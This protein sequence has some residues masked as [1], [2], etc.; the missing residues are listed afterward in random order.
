MW[1]VNFFISINSRSCCQWGERK[2]GT[3][4]SSSGLLLSV[5]VSGVLFKG[6][7]LSSSSTVP[8][9]QIR[10]FEQSTASLLYACSS[11]VLL[12]CYLQQSQGEIWINNLPERKKDKARCA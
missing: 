8:F 6:E 5:L 7:I 12:A 2:P 10:G 3:I 1:G 9:P 11:A 4:D